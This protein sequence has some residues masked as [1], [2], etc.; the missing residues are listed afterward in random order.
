MNDRQKLAVL[1]FRFGGAAL[2]VRVL[3]GLVVLFFS[4]GV[5][6]VAQ[7]YPHNVLV[8]S[9]LACLALGLALILASVPL[10]KLFG[11]GLE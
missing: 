11:R 1:L 4:P 6:L 7:Q 2:V 10:G 8:I 5:S 3:A 9:S